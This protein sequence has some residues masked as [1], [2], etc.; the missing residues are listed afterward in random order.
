MSSAIFKK[1]WPYIALIVAHA[2]W[3]L[4]FVVSKVTLIE[5]PTSSLAFTRFALACLLLL[6]FIL[7]LPKE[8]RTIKIQHMPKMIGV[9]ILMVGLSILLFFEGLKRTTAIDA[10]SLS[11]TVPILSVLAGWWFLKEKVFV[12]NLLGIGIGFLGTLVIIGVPI[13]FTGNISTSQILG[14]TLILLSGVSFVAG[15]VLSKEML[16]F[17]P[18]IFITWFSFL[19][20]AI[21]CLIPAIIDY[22]NNP[23]WIENV[24]V[25][26]VLGLLYIIL[27]SSISAFLLMNWG[28]SKV[29]LIQ[30]NLFHYIEPAIAATFAVPLL[31]ER[32]S[33][34]FIV[35]TCL[36]V[37]GV[38]W[39][40]L[41]KVIH[42]HHQ[43]KHHRS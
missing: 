37:L 34:S 10:A 33:Y 31:G 11:M 6:P 27:L 22:V 12:V 21:L 39:G 32:I 24:T 38:Y 2:I 41:G 3:G 35:G 19:V 28:L 42:Y 9:G 7:I 26:G 30:A 13:L 4:N 15:A 18:A 29:S 43:F 14:N 8:H 20:G 17:Y 16:K 36:I 40:T 5:F 1:P 23:N 25:L